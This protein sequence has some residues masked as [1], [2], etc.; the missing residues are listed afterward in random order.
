MWFPGREAIA[1]ATIV[2]RFFGNQI[3]IEP[4]RIDYPLARMVYD[5]WLSLCHDGRHPGWADFDLMAIYKAAPFMTVK[6]VEDAEDGGTEFRNRFFVTGLRE[7]L[8]F[9]GTGKRLSENYSGDAL[10][11]VTAICRQVWES[12]A[13]VQSNGR[14]VWAEDRDFITYS[15]LYMPL[16]GP[17][18]GETT[19]L[20]SVFDF[21]VF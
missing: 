21:N 11:M 18:A 14:V 19:H 7:V 15:C 13:V 12:R 3:V 4:E 9:D 10:E 1:G 2:S 5:Y 17:V 8:G 20:V 6:D 16:D